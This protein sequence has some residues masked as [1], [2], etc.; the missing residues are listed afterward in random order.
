V[1]KQKDQELVTAIMTANPLVITL[2]TPISEVG[3]IFC[4]GKFHH[5]PVVDGRELIGIVS[6]F[7]L[8]RVSF[9]QSFGVADAKSVYAVLDH[10]LDIN[11]IMTK[12]PESIPMD[13]TIA[14]AAQKLATGKFHALPVINDQH[15][16]QGI[17]TSKDLIEYLLTKL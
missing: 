13:A 11:A 10:T 12:D 2:A 7:D 9:E 4:Q 3:D 1:K 15:E 16:L 14:E 8:M 6:Y 5:L 17:V